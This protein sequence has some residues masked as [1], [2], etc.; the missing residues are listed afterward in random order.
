MNAV[1]REIAELRKIIKDYD[2]DPDIISGSDTG[3]MSGPTDTIIMRVT[4][5]E[6]VAITGMSSSFL[7][8]MGGGWDHLT[9][10]DPDPPAEHGQVKYWHLYHESQRLM[11][12]LGEHLSKRRAAESEKHS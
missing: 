1:D 3:P 2:T 5:P 7:H 8:Q 10:D 12:R 6:L 9:G 11:K 4:Y